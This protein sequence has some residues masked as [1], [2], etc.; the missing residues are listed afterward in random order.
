V[1]RL[2]LVPLTGERAG[3]AAAAAAASASV[4]GFAAYQFLPLPVLIPK[5]LGLERVDQVDSHGRWKGPCL[6]T[7]PQCDPVVP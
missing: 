5:Q 7:N 1:T 6:Q 2:R 4:S 3:A